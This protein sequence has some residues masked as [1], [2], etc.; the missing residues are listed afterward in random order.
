M[1]ASDHSIIAGKRRA[2]SD[3]KTKESVDNELSSTTRLLSIAGQRQDGDTSRP[4]V[5][6]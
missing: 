6:E 1:T 4:D 2:E 5:C 3:K